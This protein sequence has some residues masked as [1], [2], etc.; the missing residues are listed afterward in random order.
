M[1]T[2]YTWMAIDHQTTKMTLQNRGTPG[3][4]SG[5]FAPFMATMMKKAN[6]KDLNN[7]KKLMEHKEIT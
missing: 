2:T 5:L 4:F 6:A 1:E 7:I 3:G